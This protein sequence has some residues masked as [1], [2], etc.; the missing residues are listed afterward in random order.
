M[1]CSSAGLNREVDPTVR[2]AANSC[3]DTVAG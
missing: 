2:S 3:K 1:N